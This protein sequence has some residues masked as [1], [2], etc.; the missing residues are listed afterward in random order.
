VSPFR[1]FLFPQPRVSSQ[2]P[3]A[4]QPNSCASGASS[5]PSIS[6]RLLVSLCSLFWARLVCFQQLA[7]SFCK[8]RGWGIPNASTGCRGA[9][10][11]SKRPPSPLRLFTRSLEGCVILCLY[12][13]RPV[14]PR[15][16]ASSLIHSLADPCALYLPLESTFA[17]VYQNK[18]LHLP[19][20]ST[21][22]KN[23]GG[24]GPSLRHPDD[25]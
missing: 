13:C 5:F 25:P 11:T 24:G 16:F 18:Q 21:L 1:P 22:V 7:A 23:P 12:F 4:L 14:A 3:L 20:E 8:T 2:L 17:K 9:W 10:G 6:C 19:L 15:C